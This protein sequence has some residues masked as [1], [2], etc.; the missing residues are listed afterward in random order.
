MS[1]FLFRRLNIRSSSVFVPTEG[2]LPG[3]SVSLGATISLS[4]VSSSFSLNTFY[5]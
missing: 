3:T 5:F 2:F 4:E 1:L